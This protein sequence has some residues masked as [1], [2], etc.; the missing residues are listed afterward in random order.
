MRNMREI[1]RMVF[2]LFLVSALLAPVGRC[3]AKEQEKPKESPS[4]ASAEPYRVRPVYFVPRNRDPDPDYEAKFQATILLIREYFAHFMKQ[5]GFQRALFNLD[6]K[7]DGKPKIILERSRKDDTWYLPKGSKTTWVGSG[8]IQQ[9]MMQ[10]YDG[11]KSVFL[12]IADI[13]WYDPNQK[14]EV[15]PWNGGRHVTADRGGFAFV[16]NPL[17]WMGKTKPEQVEIFADAT[18]DK[19]TGPRQRGRNASILLGGM[20]HELGHAFGAQHARDDGDLM[21]SHWNFGAFF[22]KQKGQRF[23]WQGD[24]PILSKGECLLFNN[25]AFFRKPRKYD[26]NVRPTLEVELPKSV[27]PGS[28]V[29][30]K[31]TARDKDSGPAVLLV[32][33]GGVT[34]DFVDLRGKGK[35]TVFTHELVPRSP[36]K[37]GTHRLS[38][39]LYDGASNRLIGNKSFVVKGPSDR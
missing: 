24:G 36:L 27:A 28:T 38:W 2:V 5:H 25:S 33:F 17:P 1:A 34:M 8:K 10:K 37:A 26:D 3:L 7:P 31:F 14:G 6:L 11:D 22:L 29:K 4:A 21:S 35:E 9:E 39:A 18:E 19:G 20:A 15:A 12:I 32:H 23:V 30:I 13:G 16:G